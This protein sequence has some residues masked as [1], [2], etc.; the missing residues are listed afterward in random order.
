MWDDDDDD[1]YIYLVFSKPNMLIFELI[2]RNINKF[3]MRFDLLIITQ[4]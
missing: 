1:I 4:C 3:I 2:K